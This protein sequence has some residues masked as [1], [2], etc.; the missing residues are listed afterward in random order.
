VSAGL[1]L[2]DSAASGM[3]AQ[4]IALDVAARNVAAAEAA[5]PRNAYQ[6]DVPVFRVVADG[7]REARVAFAGTQRQ[8]ADDG[9]LGEM[10]A[11]MNASR[12]YDE[13]AALF[14]AGKRLVQQTI[15]LERI[16]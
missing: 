2:L 3:C 13:D 8:R 14:D 10:L 9:T 12:A 1:P 11:V 6:R 5:G 15:D 16:P 7:D 4:R